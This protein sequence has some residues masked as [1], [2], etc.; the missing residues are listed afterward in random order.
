MSTASTIEKRKQFVRNGGVN[1]LAEV[2]NREGSADRDT[3]ALD[4][5][6]PPP[7]GFIIYAISQRSIKGNQDR[8]LSE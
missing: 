3:L 8:V 6:I 7:L 5:A 1:S 2:P 4:Q